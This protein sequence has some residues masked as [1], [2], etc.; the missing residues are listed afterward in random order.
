[1]LPFHIRLERLKLIYYR[2]EVVGFGQEEVLKVRR[3]KPVEYFLR[4]WW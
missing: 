2:L 4:N 1:M 3:E